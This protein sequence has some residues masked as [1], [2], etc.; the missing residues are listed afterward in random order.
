MQTENTLCI[1]VIADGT[2]SEPAWWFSMGQAAERPNS[3]SKQRSL[4]CMAARTE[5]V[6]SGAG[7]PTGRRL[8]TVALFTV[9]LLLVWVASLMLHELGHGLAAQALGGQVVWVRVRPGIEVWPSFGQ[10]SRGPWGTAIAV[11]GYTTGPG[12]G[13]DSWQGAVV[14]LMGS[15]FNL[16]LAA[17]ALGSLW[18][19]RPRGGLRLLLITEALMF[20]DLLLYCTL[21]EFTALPDYFVFGGDVPEP[22]RSAEALGCPRWVFLL[23]V[24]LVSALM[25]W[26]L[27]AVARR[28]Q[29]SDHRWY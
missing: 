22:L 29:R 17:L 7:R 9:T 10:A 14:G 15:G 13:E 6:E 1:T 26:G 23:L 20:A 4:S 27:V 2:H 16:L 19:F 18:L 12:W 8:L 25:A 28:G 3:A 24:G 5:A 11:V 21:P